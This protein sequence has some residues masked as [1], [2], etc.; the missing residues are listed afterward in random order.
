MISFGLYV[1]LELIV[2]GRINN[3]FDA[4]NEEEIR[5]NYSLLRKEIE[6]KLGGGCKFFSGS[7]EG[8]YGNKNSMEDLEK[9]LSKIENLSKK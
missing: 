4:N 5:Q 6:I 8:K 1:P 2:G 7:G 9:S 3:S